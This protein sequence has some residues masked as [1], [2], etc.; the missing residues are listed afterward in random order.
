[1]RQVRRR[2]RSLTTLFARPKS[3]TLTT[4]A[5]VILTFAGFRS[6][7]TTPLFVRSLQRLGDLT[8]DRQRLV[9]GKAPASRAAASETA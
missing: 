5:G 1:M 4:C 9:H 8:R 2:R 6:R 7:W 3:R